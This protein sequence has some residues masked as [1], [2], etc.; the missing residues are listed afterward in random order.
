MRLSTKHHAHLREALRWT[1]TERLTPRTLAIALFAMGVP[2]LTGF[3]LGRPGMGLVIGLGSMLLSAEVPG[4]QAEGGHGWGAAIVPA[5][6]AVPVAMLLSRA[7]WGDAAMVVLSV[8]AATGVNWSRPAAGGAIRFIVF[9]ILNLGL[10]A[11]GS[12]GAH[13]GGAALLFGIGALWRAVLRRLF[14]RR[15]APAPAPAI[16]TPP[17]RVVTFDQRRHH[18]RRTMRTLQGWQYPI[19]LGFGLTAALLL[20]DLWPE[21]HFGWIVLT[22]ALLTPRTIEHLPVQITQRVAGTLA[23]VALARLILL[24]APGQVALAATVV[25]LGVAAPLARAGN[26]AVYCLLST[27]V[28]L[29]AMDAGSEGRAGLLEDRLIATIGG[30][31][32]ILLANWAMDRWLARGAEQ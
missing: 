4:Q 15:H 24:L 9:L 29:L 16:E 22:I 21:R 3:A 25:L 13:R 14:G 10:A 7:P 8:A 32:V 11:S 30:A 18:F 31:A 2:V 1:P 6:L 26:Y 19:R 12:G 20:R 27:P 28:I 23:G 5:L 17:A